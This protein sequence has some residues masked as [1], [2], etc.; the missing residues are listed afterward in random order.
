[1]E[2][3]TGE[4]M[5]RVDRR[6]IDELGIPSR[7]LMEAAGKGVAERLL[8]ELPEA[9]TAPVVVLCGKGNNG[10][11]GLVAARWIARAGGAPCVFL[12]GRADELAG[13]TR[14]SH[15]QAREAGID[16]CE[17]VDERSLE[18]V[19]RWLARAPIVIDALLGT[20]VRGAARGLMATLID[21]L[22]RSTAYV[23]SID[24]PSGL[25]ADSADLAGPAVRAKRT[26]TLCRPKLPLVLGAGATLAGRMSVI[27]IGIPDEAVRAEAT[28]LEWLDADAA[29]PLLPPRL[30]DSHKGSY[31]HLLAVA[32]SRSKSGAAVLLARGA[33][34][35]GVGLVTVATPASVQERIA[36]Q[37][38]ELMTEPL[39]ETTDGTLACEAGAAARL[40]LGGRD[41]LAVGPGLG[42]AAGTREAVR[43][44]V[45]HSPLPTVIDADGLNALA[46][47][48]REP[49]PGRPV[50]RVLT[51]HPGEAGRLLARAA[52]DLQRD[53]LGAAREL[54][55]AAGSIVVLKG[56]RS[57]V[58]TPDGRASINAS[59]NAGMAS[60]GTGDVLTGGIGAFLARGLPAFDAARLAVF[61]H[62]DAG[63]QAA[64]EL[65]TD[66][67][68]AS[69][70]VDRLPAA[71]AR[72]TRRSRV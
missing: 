2:I 32:G 58:A 51:P 39:P 22:N 63:D 50:T 33:L 62:G 65:G 17:I 23:V 40:L 28:D 49:A 56:H 34:R 3:L 11:D 35:C 70:V 21:D 24:L 9:R 15:A 55:R 72:L 52:S 27:P 19:R 46:P 12:V 1:M 5:R 16:P 47:L 57:I 60:G 13:D 53:R 26:Y 25:D 45:E 37:Q 20:G 59:G 42:T 6:A 10:G 31:G 66:G 44:I 18:E 14:A 68:I 4:Q 36:V 30:D 43:E 48:E 7:T 67:M 41:A 61:V 29:R 8:A 71:L 38:A 64:S 54:A 69:D